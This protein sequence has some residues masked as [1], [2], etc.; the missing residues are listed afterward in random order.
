M[1]QI[2]ITVVI[3][4]VAAAGCGKQGP[5]L[6]EVQGTL[7]FRGKPFP[8]VTLYFVPNAEGGT[9]GPSSMGLTDEKGHYKL[10]CAALG[11]PGA[12]VGRH[13]VLVFDSE[14]LNEPPPPRRS[15]VSVLR[16][17]ETQGKKAI[18][19]STK[20]LVSGQ[21]PLHAEVTAPGPQVI[22]LNVE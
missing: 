19:Y 12:L 15:V 2:A 6:A 8:N 1:R 3:S 11:K 9:M 16:K 22:D 13:E 20:Y 18:H 4:A 21:T 10:V 7:T 17:Q 5:N 14:S